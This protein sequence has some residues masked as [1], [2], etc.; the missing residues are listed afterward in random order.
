MSERRLGYKSEVEGRREKW[1][2]VILPKGS[3]VL[4]YI[5]MPE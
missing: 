5:F 2:N 3:E 4:E 1:K